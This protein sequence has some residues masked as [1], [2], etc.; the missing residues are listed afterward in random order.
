MNQVMRATMPVPITESELEVWDLINTGA[1]N[2]ALVSTV[3]DGITTS[4]ICWVQ[5]VE[6][7]E[8][9]PFHITPLAV[10]LNDALAAKLVDPSTGLDD[11]PKSEGHE[12]GD[13]SYCK[14]CGLDIQF[15][16]G[17]WNDRGNNGF[18]HAKTAKG[19]Q[20]HEPADMTDEPCNSKTT[21]EYARIHHC[22]MVGDHI[23]HHCVCKY[24]WTAAGRV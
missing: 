9:T 17:A 10:I 7:D 19:L 21:D 22:N 18:C 13:I 12:Y 2:L 11:P 4:A 5:W 15:L 3:M 20:A 16:Q 23:V 6:E 1:D 8:E 14:H 24:T